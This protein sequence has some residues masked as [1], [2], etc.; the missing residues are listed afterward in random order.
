MRG[1]EDRFHHARYLIDKNEGTGQRDELDFSSFSST[2]S[3]SHR[4]SCCR[5][6]PDLVDGSLAGQRKGRKLDW[7]KEGEEQ[8]LS[9]ELG[10]EWV[11][12]ML[13]C[14]ILRKWD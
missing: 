3:I 7:M 12:S 2:K 11:R 10:Q 14:G 4:R 1:T 9:A 6:D 13:G 8:E 5:L